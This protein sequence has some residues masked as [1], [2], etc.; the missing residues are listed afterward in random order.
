MR[1]LVLVLAIAAAGPAAAAASLPGVARAAAALP[2]AATTA[3]M[4]A[5][6]GLIAGARRGRTRTVAD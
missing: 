6:L 1:S 3:V 4:F 5:G 2:D